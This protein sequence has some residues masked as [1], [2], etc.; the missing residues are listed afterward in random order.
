AE[1][2]PHPWRVILRLLPNLQQRLLQDV[3]RLG[4]LVDYTLND[5]AQ[6]LAVSLIQRFERIFVSI[7]NR[8]H[9]RLI[10]GC[11]KISHV[12]IWFNHICWHWGKDGSDPPFELSARHQ[13]SEFVSER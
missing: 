9:Q 6:R 2:L 13:F 11:A 7:R 1:R 8:P 4:L 3:L 5:G 12:L 10:C